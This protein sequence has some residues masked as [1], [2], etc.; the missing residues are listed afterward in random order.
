MIYYYF[1]EG[2]ML[3]NVQHDGDFTGR[4]LKL[5]YLDVKLS[6]KFNK[7]IKFCLSLDFHI[8]KFTVR[9]QVRAKICNASIVLTN[10]INSRV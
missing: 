5:N 10:C 8:K 4:C 6:I 1:F 3:L 9:L 7:I 2:K